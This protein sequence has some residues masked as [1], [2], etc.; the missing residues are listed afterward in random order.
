MLRLTH[1]SWNEVADWRQISARSSRST[2]KLVLFFTIVTSSKLY[3]SWV[4]C[5][6]ENTRDTFK[7]NWPTVSRRYKNVACVS[8]VSL[9][10]LSYDVDYR[11]AT[12]CSLRRFVDHHIARNPTQAAYKTNPI[13]KRDR[14]NVPVPSRYPT[15]YNLI[16][17]TLILGYC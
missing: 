13:V 1:K 16:I 2:T 3:N 10:L 8:W 5:L 11:N 4:V 6:L 17:I 15:N 12:V 7:L 9:R 14:L